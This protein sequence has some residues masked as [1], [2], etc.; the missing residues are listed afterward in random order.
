[1]GG[2]ADRALDFFPIRQGTELVNDFLQSFETTL[3][4]GGGNHFFAALQEKPVGS[5]DFS[6]LFAEL[7]DSV[8]Y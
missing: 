2:T 1:M 8:S 7:P 6:N 3:V 4:I 5:A